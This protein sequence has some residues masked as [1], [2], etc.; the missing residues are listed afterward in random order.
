MER[1][2]ESS[3]ELHPSHADLLA[4]ISELVGPTGAWKGAAGSELHHHDP[5][6]AAAL[7][8]FLKYEKPKRVIDMGCGLG[9]YVRAIQAAG[10]DC[11][12]FDGHPDTSELTNGLCY[13]A[14]FEDPALPEQIA[15]GN[16]DWCLCL[17]VFEH[18]P[19]ELEG[20]LVD[21]MLA[22]AGR[23]LIVSVATP[24]QGGLGHVN[25]QPHEYVTSLL[26]ASLVSNE[27]ACFSQTVV[28]FR[29]FSSRGQ[30]TFRNSIIRI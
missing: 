18:V 11:A 29:D 10:I 22:A 30:S 4:D 24:G 9:D 19:K 6:L 28:P 15:S 3:Q 1:S 16:Y 13:T 23:G 17:E 14:D 5:G 25:E 27:L 7:A 26:E 20:Q 8:A 21:C 12:G 2:L